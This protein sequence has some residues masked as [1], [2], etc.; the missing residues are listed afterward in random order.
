MAKVNKTATVKK[1]ISPLIKKGDVLILVGKNFIL[2]GHTE[3]K[4][5]PTEKTVHGIKRNYMTPNY[6]GK[7]L[8]AANKSWFKVERVR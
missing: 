8:V 3:P 5:I 6:Y 1:D 7:E 2:K 4:E